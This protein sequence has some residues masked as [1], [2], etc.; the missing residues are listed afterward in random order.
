MLHSRIGIDDYSEIFLFVERFV[1]SRYRRPFESHGRR[2]KE[3]LN[4]RQAIAKYLITVIKF[5]FAFLIFTSMIEHVLLQKKNDVLE[6][7]IIHVGE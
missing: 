4:F 5:F 6:I 2:T 7:E 1:S 3:T